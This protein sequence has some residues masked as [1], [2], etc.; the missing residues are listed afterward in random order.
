MAKK[1]LTRAEMQERTKT[2]LIEAAYRLFERGGFSAVSLEEIAAEAGYSKGAV[3]SN[4]DS[5]ED[6]FLLL[7]SR[8]EAHVPDTSM[9]D[10]ESLPMEERFARF[11]ASAVPRVTARQR[12][13]ALEIRAFAL[14]DHRAR[15]LAASRMRS[16]YEEMAKVVENRAVDRDRTLAVSGLDLVLIMQVIVDGLTGLRAFL[17]DLVTDELCA[18]AMGLLASLIERDRSGQRMKSRVASR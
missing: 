7:L 5:K 9:F 15:E 6:L 3:Y 8:E 12:A 4:F 16:F 10:D 2:R 14:R 11:G 17:P 1:R 18:K 13:L